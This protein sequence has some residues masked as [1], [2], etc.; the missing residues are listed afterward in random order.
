[1]LSE[2]KINE[3]LEHRLQ[4][5]QSMCNNDVKNWPGLGFLL[6]FGQLHSFWFGYLQILKP[7]IDFQKIRPYLIIFIT[8]TLVFMSFVKD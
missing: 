6:L 2:L 7:R 1:M 4:Y 3:E 8:G 5:F